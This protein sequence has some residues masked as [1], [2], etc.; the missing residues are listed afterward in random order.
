MTGVTVRPAIVPITDAQI[1]RIHTT[2]TVITHTAILHTLITRCQTINNIAGR[3]AV[4]HTDIA[5]GTAGLDAVAEVH[6]IKEMVARDKA[7]TGKHTRV[8]HAR[9]EVITVEGV[10]C[11]FVRRCNFVTTGSRW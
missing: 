4:L 3:N 11:N 9:D 8:K 7:T 1:N 6:G 10:Q 5:Q 2:L